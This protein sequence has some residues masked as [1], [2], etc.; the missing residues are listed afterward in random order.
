MTDHVR[1]AVIGGCGI[2]CCPA[3]QGWANRPTVPPAVDAPCSPGGLPVPASPDADAGLA[4]ASDWTLNVS[5]PDAGVLRERFGFL[6][7]TCLMPVCRRECMMPLANSGAVDD[8][9]LAFTLRDRASGPI[10]PT[11]A[12]PFAAAP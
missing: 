7:R 2:L 4:S 9:P 3:L 8:G 6:R 5:S 12:T 10:V 11:T 1:L